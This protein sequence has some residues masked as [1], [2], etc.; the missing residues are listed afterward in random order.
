MGI[1]AQQASALGLRI[2]R[3][4]AMDPRQVGRFLGVNIPKKDASP[5]LGRIDKAMCKWL[6]ALGLDRH[7]EEGDYGITYITYRVP[8]A[9]VVPFQRASEPPIKVT[10]DPSVITWKQSAYNRQRREFT[11]SMR[12]RYNAIARK[13]R[14]S[15]GGAA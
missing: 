2:R 4:G 13:E 9:K 8:V 11:D 12:R 5:Q 6:P 15:G 3:F 10:Y 1:N 14:R 7:E